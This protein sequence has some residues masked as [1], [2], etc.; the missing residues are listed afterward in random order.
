MCDFHTFIRENGAF[1]L[2]VCTLFGACF[3]ALGVYLLKSRCTKIKC[4][5]V[6]C[7]RTP[8]AEEHLAEVELGGHVS[9]T[10]AR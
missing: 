5:C 2:T 8:I 4:C 10:R 1:V 7:V 6:E 3:S 9:A